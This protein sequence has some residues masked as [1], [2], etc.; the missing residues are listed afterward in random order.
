MG[1]HVGV[2][3]LLLI[4]GS[5]GARAAGPVPVSPGNQTGIAVVSGRCP[6]FHWTAA[7]GAESVGVANGVGHLSA[8]SVGIEGVPGSASR[9]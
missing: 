3:A 5:G 1:P 8:R 9:G 6:T 2:V 7:Q 4:L